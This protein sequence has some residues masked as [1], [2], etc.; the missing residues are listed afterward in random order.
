M[1]DPLKAQ[2]AVPYLEQL[3]SKQCI[4]HFQKGNR[5]ADTRSTL[6]TVDSLFVSFE[7]KRKGESQ[8]LMDLTLE[9]YWY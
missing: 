8:I 7:V 4:S 6:A 1:E 5:Y 3:E 2:L 9:Q